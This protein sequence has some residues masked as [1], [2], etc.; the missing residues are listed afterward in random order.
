M[1]V[2]RRQWTDKAGKQH[3]AWMVDVAFERP[4]GRVV[5]FRKISPVNTRRGAEE[6]E[7]QVRQELLDGDRQRRKPVPT[8]SSFST[9]YMTH[10]Q[11]S[12]DNKPSTLATKEV[13]LKPLRAAF[14]D[15]L[16]DAIDTAAVDSYKSARTKAGL[17]KKT[18]NE[19]LG[20]L[21]HLLHLAHEWGELPELPSIKRFRGANRHEI[22]F[23]TDAEA[24]RLVSLAGPRWGGMI[25]L[26]LNTGLRLGELCGLSWDCVDL[27]NGKLRVAKNVWQG[28]LGTPKGNRERTVPLNAAAKACLKAQPRRLDSSWVFPQKDGGFIRNPQWTCED[29]ISR[30][31]TAAA[32]G[33]PVAWHIMRHTFA[34]NLVMRGASLK[35]VQELLGHASIEQTMRYAHLAPEVKAD[36]VKLLDQPGVVTESKEKTG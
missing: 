23:L 13:K 33:R 9:R 20:V 8:F 4:D 16:L 1:A 3:E 18:V 10:C 27:K 2:R 14:G 11:T 26:A 30:I 22:D 19:E 12:T 29:A 36:T 21:A 31:S 15:R 28:I 6:Y 35:A 17:S 34:S 5:R 32:L 25:T 24:E 7:R